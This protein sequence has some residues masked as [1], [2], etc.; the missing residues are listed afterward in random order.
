MQGHNSVRLSLSPAPPAL[1]SSRRRVRRAKFLAYAACLAWLV[2]AAA[3]ASFLPTT[4]DQQVQ[5][6]AVVFRGTVTQTQS[7]VDPSD[8]MIRT[9]IVL[10]VR[11]VFKGR[12]PSSVVLVEWGGEVSGRATMVGDAPRFAPGEEHLVFASRRP[13][14]TLAVIGGPAGALTLPAA[15]ALAGGT[16]SSTASRLLDTLRT[17]TAAGPLPGD[18]VTDQAV[19]S[20]PL[21]G[22][23]ESFN[24]QPLNSPSSSATNFM[25]GSDG[26]APRYLQPDRGEGIPYWIDADY[27]PSGITLSQAIVAVQTAL[28][29]WTNACSVRYRFA[30]I[31]SFGMAAGNVPDQNGQLFIQLHDHYGAITGGGDTLGI[32]GRTLLVSTTPSGWTL[33]GNVAGNDFHQTIQ[34]FVTIANT[35]SFF[36]GNITNLETVLCHEIGHSLS[37][38]HS[39]NDPNE[40]NTLLT[41]SIMYYVAT[42]GRGATLNAWDTN[43]IRQAYPATNTPPWCYSRVMDIVTSPGTITT[44]GVNTV[45][46]PGFDLQTTNLSFVTADAWPGSS[47]WSPASNG[48]ITYSAGAWYSDSGR[49]DPAGGSFYA[50]IYGRYSD[51]VNYSPYATVKVISFWSDSYSEGIPDSWRLKYFG[52]IDPS[53]GPRRHALDDFDG[54]GFNNVTEWRLGSDPTDANSNLRI[55]NFSPTNLQWAAKGYEVYQVVSSTDFVHWTPALNPI[56]PT[57]FVPGTN[58][59]NLTNSI[60]AASGFTNGGPRQFFRVLKLP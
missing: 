26:I 54:D 36:T 39:S 34:G 45:W 19:G 52:S 24:P 18:D 2:A 7:Y 15:G 46:V 57:N 21:A 42:A 40:T 41:G 56:V 60:G 3:H 51:G 30:G 58:I 8:Q 9:R 5:S 20:L 16:N 53:A 49:L 10:Q 35:S 13:N 22:V 59:F 50:V 14:G 48:L 17:A 29:A 44:P 12:V 23:P 43:S 6:A 27:L 32:G 31:R 11:E 38:A 55:S 1:L 47:Y 28:A 33:G 4:T 37:L 25:V